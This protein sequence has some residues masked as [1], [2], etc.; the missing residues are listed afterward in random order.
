MLLIL[1]F[2]HGDKIQF[3]SSVLFPPTLDE[4][5]QI[6]GVN[7]RSSPKPDHAGSIPSTIRVSGDSHTG[8]NGFFMNDCSLSCNYEKSEKPKKNAQTQEGGSL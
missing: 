1:V 8:R 4:E 7:N 3:L 6:T 2:F 5:T